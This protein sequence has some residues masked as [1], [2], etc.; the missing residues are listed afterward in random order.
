MSSAQTK[1]IFPFGCGLSYTWLPGLQ[2]DAGPGGDLAHG[3]GYRNPHGQ[4]HRL[5]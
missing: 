5:A 3:L 2:A 1:P 4:Q